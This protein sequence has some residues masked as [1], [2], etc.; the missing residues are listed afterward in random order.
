MTTASRP[1]IL[2]NKTYNWTAIRV[3][4]LL[5]NNLIDRRDLKTLMQQVSAGRNVTD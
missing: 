4:R 2:K 5:R 1:L 3:R